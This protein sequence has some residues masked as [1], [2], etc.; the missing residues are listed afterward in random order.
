[1]SFT[2]NHIIGKSTLAQGFTI[3]KAAYSYL[4]L[5]EKGGKRIIT[6]IYAKN[7]RTQVLLRSLNNALGHVQV[8]YEGKIGIQF[9]QWILET[10]REIEIGNLDKINN[11]LDITI[12]SDDIWEIKTNAI[13]KRATLYFTDLRVHN[14]KENHL[15]ALDEFAEITGS[16][17]NIDFVQDKRQE[18]Y[19]NKIC[20]ELSAKGWLKEQNVAKVDPNIRLKC[21]FRKGMWQIEVEFG[22][23]RTYYQ[24]IVKFA[25]S[26]SAGLMKI[27]GLIVPDSLFA[28]HLC[29]LGKKN[30]IKNSSLPNA[31]YSGMMNFGNVPL[32]LTRHR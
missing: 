20:T 19:N 10:F 7:R 25:I 18:Y 16:I 1:M 28:Q 31:Q 27:G 14:I 24:D 32:W 5:P 22:N 12:I 13:L 8:R 15:L 9:R 21:D 23:A 6:L 30:A 17:R 4:S 26:Y 2:F 3:P 29:Q 11:S